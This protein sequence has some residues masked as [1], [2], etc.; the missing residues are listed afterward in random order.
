MAFYLRGYDKC[1]LWFFLSYLSIGK[2]WILNE[3]FFTLE[4]PILLE[5]TS[6]GLKPRKCNFN[7][8]F[9]S[10]SMRGEWLFKWI[11]IVSIDWLFK[12]SYAN[13]LEIFF[14][15]IRLWRSDFTLEVCSFRSWSL[16]P[17]IFISSSWYHQRLLILL[18][19][20][21]LILERFHIIPAAQSWI[22]WSPFM[23]TVA[24]IWK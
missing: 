14:N 12:Y 16:L 6:Y 9:H 3:F 18:L 13:L 4:V 2:Q 1:E 19:F 17:K 8:P 7:E 20:S 24:S 5:T 22:S 15:N 11:L 10:K 21:S 23:I